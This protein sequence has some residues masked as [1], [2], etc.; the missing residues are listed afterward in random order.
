MNIP[1]FMPGQ[2]LSAVHLNQLADAI[3]TGRITSFVGGRVQITTGGTMLIADPPP[4]SG[5]GTATPDYSFRVFQAPAEE[6]DTRP[7]FYVYGE[8]YLLKDAAEREYIEITG[9]NT[10]YDRF[11]LPAE[12]P[13]AIAITLEFD[14]EMK[15]T[16]AYRQEGKIADVFETY[17]CPVERDSEATGVD[18]LRQTKMH[19]FIAEVIDPTAEGADA[20][21]G[22]TVDDDG[23]QKK[24]IQ[25]VDTDMLFTWSVVDGLA[26]RIAVPW[27]KACRAVG[28][29]PFVPVTPP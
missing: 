17:P 25:L 20:R 26:A 8:S 14:N 29:T 28:S 16:A 6:G 19:I 21:D 22:T 23:V 2:A 13:A 27:K 4:S 10:D 12:M 5:G 15:I 7:F 1:R 3:R 11:N 24:I 18:Y 9:V